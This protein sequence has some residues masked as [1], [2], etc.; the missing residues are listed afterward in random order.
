MGPY[1][2]A[3]PDDM[4]VPA[5][6]TTLGPGEKIAHALLT[7]TPL[8]M[9]VRRVAGLDTS[10]HT[11]L[12]GAF[13][14]IAVLLIAMGAVSLQIITSMSRQSRLLD[15]ARERVDASRQIEHALAV[16]MDVT[17]NALTLRDQAGIDSILRENTRFTDALGPLAGDAPDTER[18]LIVRIHAVEDK[19]RATV[20]HVA[21][22]IREGNAD[23]AMALHLNDGYPLYREITT[24][25]TQVVRA[26]ETQMGR[27]RHSVEATNRRAVVLMGG[28]AAASICLALVLGFVISWSFITP[29]RKAEA[30]LAQV[31]KGDFG[32][33]IE[34][35]NRDEFG[36]LAARMNQMSRE[37]HQ[38]YDEQRTLNLQLEH[39]SKAKSDFLASM[40]HELRTPLNAILGF[41]E[42]ILG[43]IYGAVPDDLK[44]PLTDIQ[45]SGKH[46][47]G[48]INNVL[49][50]SKIEAGHMELALADYSVHDT[51]MSVVVA[52][53]PLAAQKGLA[54]VSAVPED[55][56]IARGDGGRI[57]QCLMNLVGN[58]LKFTLEGEV[59]IAVEVDGDV[60]NYR[61]SDTGTGIAADRL[62]TVFGAFRQEDPTIAGQFGGTGLGLSISKKFVEMHGGRIWVE[63]E[64]GRGSTFFFA[65]PLR[66]EPAKT[67]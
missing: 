65:L 22:L 17:R 55:I 23:D 3:G 8:G 19:L 12:L 33:T 46:L 37:L 34:V 24:L 14:L 57:T 62:E 47:L 60:L 32:A 30:F 5:R 6:E 58:A 4:T 2:P 31:A 53:R 63:S 11:K 50:L 27:L 66:A 41:N 10:V 38:L 51:V 42:M 67:S 61:V 21:H 49:D 1:K 35:P 29:V 40:S 20:G 28:F 25:V 44:V 64:V 59:A 9:L 16:Q 43:E 26:E 56:P 54:L 48:L 18:A 13:L 15:R 52:L 45:H 7:R 39:A 36:A